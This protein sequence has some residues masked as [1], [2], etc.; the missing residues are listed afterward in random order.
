MKVGL[1]NGFTSYSLLPKILD[2][3]NHYHVPPTPFLSNQTGRQET[4]ILDFSNGKTIGMSM[5]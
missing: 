2:F 4:E 3:I 5:P 1:D